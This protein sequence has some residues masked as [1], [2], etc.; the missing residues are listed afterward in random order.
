MESKGI[1]R[2]REM[3]LGDPPSI[4]AQ[5][6]DVFEQISGYIH[7][8]RPPLLFLSGGSHSCRAFSSDYGSNGQ[9]SFP[10][11]RNVVKGS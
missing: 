10:G 7:E 4:V 2:S 9:V 8:S 6:S 11:S 1:V 3:I 5:D